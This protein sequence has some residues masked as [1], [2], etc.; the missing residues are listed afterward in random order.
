MQR[1]DKYSNPIGDGVA[2]SAFF[3]PFTDFKGEFTVSLWNGTLQRREESPCYYL[4]DY[5]TKNQGRYVDEEDTRAKGMILDF[6]DGKHR[7]RFVAERVLSRA[8]CTRRLVPKKGRPPVFAVVPAGSA[9]AHRRRYEF[10]C[11]RVSAGTGADNGYGIYEVEGWRD[12]TGRDS[13]LAETMKF[14]PEN[15]PLLEGR[16]ILLFDDVY[17]TGSSFRQTARLMLEG[18]A[19]TVTGLFLGKSYREPSRN[20]YY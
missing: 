11:N 4:F 20:R 3:E 5:F 18:G 2:Y 9:Y 8:V 6:K 16:D 12:G 1:Q 13:E 14:L 10:F 7:G 19:R 17:V 15:R